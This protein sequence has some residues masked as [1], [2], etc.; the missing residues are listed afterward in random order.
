MK[1]ILFI[2]LS[3]LM[4]TGCLKTVGLNI[5]PSSQKPLQLLPVQWSVVKIDNKTVYTLDQQ[6]FNNLSLNMEETQN[7]LWED[8]NLLYVK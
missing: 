5:Q 3:C 2:L 6:N 8:Y 4:L 7:R 1:R